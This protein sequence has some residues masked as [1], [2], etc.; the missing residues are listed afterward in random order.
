MLLIFELGEL[1]FSIVSGWSDM[2]WKMYKD[3][4]SR[5]YW[6]WIY[7]RRRLIQHSRTVSDR[8]FLSGAVSIVDF[9]EESVSNPVLDRIGNPLMR[10]YWQA[11]KRV[12][13]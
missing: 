8:I 6:K 5:S 1:G 4:F 3:W 12:I 13:P 10:W 7:A 2:K 9:Q 11:V